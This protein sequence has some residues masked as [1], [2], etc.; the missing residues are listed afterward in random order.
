MFTVA[1][2]IQKILAFLFFWYVSHKLGP[3][4][5]GQYIFALSFTTMF[6]VF[7]DI[8]MGTVLTR[9]VS[10]TPDKSQK[11]I[12][13][14]LGLKILLGV[15]VLAIMSAV[16]LFSDR[17][18]LVKQL[19]MLAG[20]VMVSDSIQILLASFFRGIQTLRYESTSV[21]I[22]QFVEILVGVIALE[23]TGD[24]RWAIVS[25]ASASVS[26]FLYFAFVAWKKY[27]IVLK[28]SFNREALKSF[29]KLLPAFAIATIVVRMYATT[30][31]VILE[32]L[33]GSIA[34]GVYAVP[35]KVVTALQSLFAGSFAAAMYPAMSSAFEQQKEKLSSL[36]ASSFHYL[37]LLSFPMAAGLASVSTGVIHTIWPEYQ[38]AIVPLIVMSLAL[39]F[40]FLSF[41]TG[42]LLNATNQQK[43]TTLNRIIAAALSIILNIIFIPLYG[44]VAAASIFLFTS[45]VLFILDTVHV[46]SELQEV[47]IWA[48]SKG[49]R[50]VLASGAMAGVTWW[51]Q[52][53]GIPV[54]AAVIVGIA[55]Y[56]LFI[57][58]LQA[59]TRQE[60]LVFMK[61]I[62]SRKAIKEPQ[63]DIH[64]L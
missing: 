63:E 64:Q 60:L 51:V 25:V 37:S 23:I 46:R 11:L 50:I 17:P 6:A 22:F 26:A 45:I 58:F 39:P 56:A 34:V 7:M 62:I 59:V 33:A 8:G 14:A 36:L 18:V 53:Q 27:S 55:S 15:I 16:V 35:A 19:I 61:T 2:G 1:L 32:F 9:E 54:W 20:I 48:K 41:P 5:L 57:A 3:G 4:G 47:Y 12:S 38:S 31:V 52:T 28:P 30:D 29:S 43:K 40:V 42:S 44:V 49:I 13:S 24:V 10:R 21:L